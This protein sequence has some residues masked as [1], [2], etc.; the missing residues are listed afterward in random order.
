MLIYISEQRIHIMYYIMYWGLRTGETGR[1]SFAHKE[2][3]KRM[4]NGG[5]PLT[6]PK[7]TCVFSWSKYLVSSIHIHNNV[8][9][10][11]DD[12]DSKLLNSQKPNFF[13]ELF[14]Y[15]KWN[16]RKRYLIQYNV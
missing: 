5:L 9:D 1:L 7:M 3:D 6:I 2:R 10:N 11:N 8:C 16:A 15:W 13:D 12:D 4:E 14:H